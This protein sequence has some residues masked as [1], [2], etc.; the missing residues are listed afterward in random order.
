MRQNDLAA[1]QNLAFDITV[2][3]W[4]RSSNPVVTVHKYRL[5]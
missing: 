3:Q 2:E 1:V 5:S 4:I